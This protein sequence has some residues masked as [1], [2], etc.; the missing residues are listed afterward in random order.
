MIK[1]KMIEILKSIEILNGISKHNNPSIN[2]Q[3]KF[4]VGLLNKNLKEYV[5]QYLIELQDLINEYEIQYIDYNFYNEDENKLDEF[6]KIVNELENTE[7]EIDQQKIY[8]DDSFNELS[9]DEMVVLMPYFD[10]GQI[11]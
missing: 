10:Y 5:D 7:I 8:C 3:F 1:V 11:E 9:G 6:L 2:R 4:K